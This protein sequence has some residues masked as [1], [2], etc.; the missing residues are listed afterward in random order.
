MSKEGTCT[1]KTLIVLLCMFLALLAYCVFAANKTLPFW[2][3][4]SSLE[5]ASASSYV[6]ASSG[7]ASQ[8]AAAT[9][10]AVS[11][12]T[13]SVSASASVG[14]T[15]SS[16]PGATKYQPVSPSVMKG[17][18]ISQYDGV[19]GYQPSKE[20]FTSKIDAVFDQLKAFGF[21]TVVV[22]LH[23][24]GDAYY[25][26]AYFPWSKYCSSGLGSNPGYDPTAIMV[27]AAHKRGLSF[28]AW[29]NPLRMQTDADMAKTPDTFPVKK[30]YNSSLK[31][32]YIV[33]QDGVWYLNP[34]YAE[35]R[36]LVADGVTEIVKKYKVDA[37]HI[38]DYFY[39]TE[40]E[41]FDRAAFTAS[42]AANLTVW[43]MQNIDALIM[44]MN[45]AIK[46]VNP[47]VRFGI[48][49]RAILANDNALGADVTLWSSE[50]GYL[51]YIVP[52][53]YFGYEHD[54]PDARY[55]NCINIWNKLVTAP[56]VSLVI[57]LAAHKIGVKDKYAG[58]GGM[59]WI[60]N[61]DI[62]ERQ[63]ADA[64]KLGKYKGFCIFS[65]SGLFAD[66][67]AATAE[68]NYLKTVMG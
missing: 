10:A 42:H 8:T 62:L 51:D 7:T 5:N 67:A 15:V 17:I 13:A 12:E 44:Q 23:P 46:A 56:G 60:N 68:R 25:P 22:Q 14:A 55:P 19:D 33:L 66:T 11:S 57:G 36:K 48:S 26:S 64:K 61:H 50:K 29:I 27:E 45:A 2:A 31:G 21:N 3:V 24:N 32:K 52:Q 20:A 59:E 41:S 63:V 54:N 30:W 58:N 35:T 28:H 47:K 34:A 9:S 39:P 6:P 16:T 43:R 49:P 1:K 4:G 40:S 65:Y 38:D 53:V 18:W 37:V